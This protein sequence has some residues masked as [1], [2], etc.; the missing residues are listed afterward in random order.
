M[1]FSPNSYISLIQQFDRFNQ[2][3]DFFFLSYIVLISVCSFIRYRHHDVP[4]SSEMSSSVGEQEQVDRQCCMPIVVW[5]LNFDGICYAKDPV[6][7]VLSV[8]IDEAS[9]S[10]ETECF[11]VLSLSDD[12]SPFH[13]KS[14]ADNAN[15]SVNSETVV[16]PP[17]LAFTCASF[18]KQ[19]RDIEKTESSANSKCRVSHLYLLCNL[20]L[21]YYDLYDLR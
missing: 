20:F 7:H 14:T 17:S 4:C 12:A 10:Y 2:I 9:G 16:I 15:S 5:A 3:A 19:S 11:P 21:N 8:P 13:P 6:N 18:S 1:E